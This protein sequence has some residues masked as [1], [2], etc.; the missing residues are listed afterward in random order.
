MGNNTSER[1][2]RDVREEAGPSG[3][4]LPSESQDMMT[5]PTDRAYGHFVSVDDSRDDLVAPSPVIAG[6]DA[7]ALRD[8]A[9]LAIDYGSRRIGLACKPK[10]QSV[11]LPLP[12]QNAEPSEKAIEAIQRAIAERNVGI[13]VT[14]L[15][16]HRD[17]TQA[18]EVKRFTR[19]LRRGVRGVRWRFIDETLTT[20][21]ALDRRREMGVESKHV[22]AHAACLILESYLEAQ[23][24]AGSPDAAAA[25]DA[26]D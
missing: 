20:A 25:P 26:D 6:M 17:M 4:V 8:V 21:E 14:G 2:E 19:K 11:V 3:A 16:I 12:V 24:R 18:R 1:A 22:D 5:S 13:V 7:D 23:S 9:V 15:P 10:G